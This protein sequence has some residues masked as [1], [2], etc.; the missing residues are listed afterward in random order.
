M[1]KNYHPIFRALLV[2]V[3][4]L[5]W[6]LTAQAQQGATGDQTTGDTGTGTATIGAAPDTS[7]FD[8]IQRGDSVTSAATTGFGPGAT[9]G[10]GGTSAFGGGGGGFGGFGGLGGLFGGGGFGQGSQSAKPLIR[11]RL[12]SAVTF[13]ARPTQ[14][15]QANANQRF[16][17]L[18]QQRGLQNVQINMVGR[19][20]VINGTAS[21]DRDRRMAEL[22]MRLEPGVS[23]IQNN[24]QVSQ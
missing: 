18:P 24:V 12:R 20:A 15:V 7:A 11:T 3:S 2:T 1:M 5:G 17:Q 4:L 22:L 10:G 9:Q 23:Q 19:T 16:V 13:T 14:Q 6:T 8:Q 21:S